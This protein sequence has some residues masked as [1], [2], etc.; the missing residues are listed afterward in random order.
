MKTSHLFP[1]S[2][3]FIHKTC[4][5]EQT[6]A[7]LVTIVKS[8]SLLNR[9]SS[10]AKLLRM[11][12]SCSS[13]HW[14]CRHHLLWLL[15]FYNSHQGSKYRVLQDGSFQ[16]I[17]SYLISREYLLHTFLIIWTGWYLWMRTFLP[18]NNH[19]FFSNKFIWYDGFKTLTGQEKELDINKFNYILASCR[20]LRFLK[21]SF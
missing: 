18:R 2:R 5:C 10:W 19:D 21:C 14:S 13:C 15:T 11:K 1:L 12:T 16:K 8:C 20:I 6:A 7:H 4:A 9:W 17:S 3:P